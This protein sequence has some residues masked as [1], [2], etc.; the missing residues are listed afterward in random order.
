MF[1]K[2]FLSPLQGDLADEV[3]GALARGS[4]LIPPSALNQMIR[5][6]IEWCADVDAPDSVGAISSADFVHVV[7][8]VNGDQEAQDRTDFFTTWPPTEDELAAFNEAMA[9][10]DH[11]LLTQVRRHMLMEFARAQTN[12][13]PV[14]AGHPRHDLSAGSRPAALPHQSGRT[15][16]R[17]TAVSAAAST[18][19]NLLSAVLIEMRDANARRR[20]ALRPDV[21]SDELLK[22]LVFLLRRANHDGACLGAALPTPAKND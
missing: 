3:K 19:S 11:L 21:H 5:E 22:R 16:S 14:P 1:E 20:D 9:H 7:P 13:T 18:C 2:K 17:Q 12:A 6:A 8:S 4:R 10:D 15:P